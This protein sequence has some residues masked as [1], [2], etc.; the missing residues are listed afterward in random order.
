[1]KGE[2]I[3]KYFENEWLTRMQA[4]A[5]TVSIKF[6]ET[7]IFPEIPVGTVTHEKNLNIK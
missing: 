1:M 7:D 5:C 2:M 3:I 6:V 4:K